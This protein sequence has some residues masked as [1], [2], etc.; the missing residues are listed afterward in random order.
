[1]EQTRQEH[2]TIL[3]HEQA[4]LEQMHTTA[5]QV[6]NMITDMDALSAKLYRELVDWHTKFPEK[7]SLDDSNAFWSQI[8]ELRAV[9]FE[10]DSILRA[11]REHEAR[12][13]TLTTQLVK[14]QETIHH[15]E[16]AFDSYLDRLNER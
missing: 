16:K 8:K 12:Q 3:P 4:A 13:Q 1:M 2:P 9:Q 15:I 14:A 6:R 5:E 10:T 7:P 11:I